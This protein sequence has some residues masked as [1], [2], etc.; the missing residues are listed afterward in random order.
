MRGSYGNDNSLIKPGI[1]LLISIAVVLGYLSFS[2]INETNS[3]NLSE[4]FDSYN[5]FS[6]KISLQANVALPTY[7]IGIL[8]SIP[9]SNDK[10]VMLKHV[11]SF[12]NILRCKE[13]G[14]VLW[15]AELPTETDDVYTNVN[16][17][18]QNLCAHSRSCTTVVLDLETGEISP[19][20]T[21]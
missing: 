2:P 21:F 4:P 12:R 19:S 16:W 6:R 9:N 1:V 17:Q 8:L 7:D 11:Q 15:Q 10:I 20:E 13:D 3:Q 5:K 14:S 18:D